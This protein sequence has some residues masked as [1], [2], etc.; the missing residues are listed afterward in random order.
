ME[1]L[2]DY[3][4]VSLSDIGSLSLQRRMDSKFLLHE[5][6]VQ[7]LL[8]SLQQRCDLLVVGGVASQPYRTLYF[9]TPELHFYH[10]HHNGR[11]RRLK[12]R[13]RRY[14]R[15]GTVFNEV[16]R[17]ESSGQTVKHRLSREGLLDQIDAPFS[18]LI[19]AH[20][21]ID[22]AL[23]A[24]SL[25]VYFERITLVDKVRRERL[26]IDRGL[27]Y[28]HGGREIAVPGLAIVELK[29]EQSYSTTTLRRTLRGLPMLEI[30][31]SKYC[32]GIASL[33]EVRR[34]NFQQKFR[35]VA[36]LCNA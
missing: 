7:P 21:P 28:H 2:A 25:T 14:E 11:A 20:A 4:Q 31:F 26:T 8:D 10:E 17:K 3:Q 12:V 24:P 1:A 6:E 30:G 36:R 34:H 27:R 35:R 16:K 9:D 32:F 18:S 19:N 22:P 15:C 13:S 33:Y 29:R 23:L 5:R